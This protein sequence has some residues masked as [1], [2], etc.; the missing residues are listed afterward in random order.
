M[1]TGVQNWWVMV[2]GDGGMGKLF[3]FHL[4]GKSVFLLK[5][6]N[7]F[8]LCL[9]FLTENY[10]INVFLEELIDLKGSKRKRNSDNSRTI[11]FLYKTQRLPR[12]LTDETLISPFF[13]PELDLTLNQSSNLFDQV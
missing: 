13:Q 2:K 1:T 5:D 9:L 8:Q 3:D 10:T 11:G 6:Q 7:V 12:Y 4:L